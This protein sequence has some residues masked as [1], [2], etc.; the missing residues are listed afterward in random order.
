MKK[1]LRFITMGLLLLC[2]ILLTMQ[3]GAAKAAEDGEQE[4]QQ[5]EQQEEQ[6]QVQREEGS[7][8]TSDGF[9]YISYDGSTYTITGYEGTGGDITIPGKINGKKVTTLAMGSFKDISTITSVTIGEG[10]QK[11]YNEVFSNCSNLETISLPSSVSYISNAF[12]SCEKLTTF[13]VAKKNKNYYAKDGILM[14]KGDSSVTLVAYPGG[15]AGEYT[16]PKEVTY[17]GEQSFY[18]ASGLTKVT[19]PGTCKSIS[20]NAFDGCTSLTTV[21]IKNGGV[22]GINWYTFAHCTSLTKV[23]VPA[24]LEW[25]SEGAFAGC[26]NLKS[27][28]ISKS[29]KLVKVKDGVI[30]CYYENGNRRI[31]ELLSSVKL[32]E[33]TFTVPKDIFL[34]NSGAFAEVEGLTTIDFSKCKLESFDAYQFKGFEN[35]TII[36]KKDSKLAKS[37]ENTEYFA[38]CTVKYVK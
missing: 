38:E 10:I 31:C 18:G 37:I 11:L 35:G 36:I 25:I 8:V 28:S 13:K 33:G 14:E 9:W 20:A 2:T 15:R 22:A 23:A 3:S 12:T 7:E 26:T 21:D 24:S 5:E 4:V 17:I 16:I 34:L 27:L 32:T 30:Y 1:N 29:N 19:I 6:Q